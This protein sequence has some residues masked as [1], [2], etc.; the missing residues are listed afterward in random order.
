MSHPFEPRSSQPSSY[1]YSII[2]SVGSPVFCYFIVA[3]ML[4]F[5]RMNVCQTG[6]APGIVEAYHFRPGLTVSS[7]SS[8]VYEFLP[9]TNAH[10]PARRDHPS[11][12]R[13][14]AGERA[15]TSDRGAPVLV[16]IED[17]EGLLP[18]ER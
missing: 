12:E 8:R 14:S 17:L 2:S 6:F 15:R 4:G 3:D 9:R 1:D 13:G 5:S 16:K 11:S 7:T 18:S 10:H